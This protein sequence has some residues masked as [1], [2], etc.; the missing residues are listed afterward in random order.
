M[1][2]M[3]W[4]SA[5]VCRTNLLRRASD[6]GVWQLAGLDDPFDHGGKPGLILAAH[7]LE[8][9]AEPFARRDI[10]YRGARPDFSVFH[11]EVNLDRRID[12]ACPEC[13]DEQSPHTQVPDPGCVFNPATSP[14]SP[15]TL[16]RFHPL[17]V[18]S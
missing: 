2:I 12:G 5:G 16:G 1:H 15:H 17:M 8:L 9:Q 7:G 13:L 6:F 10:A 11:K 18:S 14:H 3:R 4:S